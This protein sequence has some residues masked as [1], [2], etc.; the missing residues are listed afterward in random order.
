[1]RGGT[2]AGVLAREEATE[3]SVLTLAFEPLAAAKGA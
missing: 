3:Q 2:V 1:M